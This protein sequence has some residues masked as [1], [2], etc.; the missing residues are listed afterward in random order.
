V[1]I[2]IFSPIDGMRAANDKRQT[3]NNKHLSA[4]RNA[5]NKILDPQ[6]P[7]RAMNRLRKI[8]YKNQL[9]ERREH[10]CLIPTLNVGRVSMRNSGIC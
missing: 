5:K 10:G 1:D 2:D 9:M 7:V 4:D 6:S 3:T 8:A